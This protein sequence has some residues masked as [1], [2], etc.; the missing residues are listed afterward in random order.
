[1]DCHFRSTECAAFSF[2]LRSAARWNCVELTQSDP[3][4]QVVGE[5]GAQQLRA[6][7]GL[8]AH[9]EAP[10]TEFA[11]QPCVAKLHHPSP[12]AILPLRLH[13]RHPVPE[14]QDRRAYRANGFRLPGR[15]GTQE[16]SSISSSHRFFDDDEGP[17][18]VLSLPRNRKPSTKPENEA[19]WAGGAAIASSCFFRAHAQTMPPATFTL[20]KRGVSGGLRYEQPGMAHPL[21]ARRTKG[22]SVYS[23]ACDRSPV[24]LRIPRRSRSTDPHL[25]IRRTRMGHPKNIFPARRNDEVQSGAACDGEAGGLEH[26][27]HES[28]VECGRAMGRS[29]R[30]KRMK[31]LNAGGDELR[32][33]SGK[34]R[35]ARTGLC[36]FYSKYAR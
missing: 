13:A 30:L 23:A 8:P 24:M 16:G 10:Q 26:D 33:Y 12:S 5:V 32:P 4:L 2:L 6:G 19:Q 14:R 22:G 1:M 34:P 27:G 3:L 21:S 35:K 17:Q 28:G 29:R 31:R 11:F 7:F 15:L 9:V 36:D 20:E 25:S 18:G